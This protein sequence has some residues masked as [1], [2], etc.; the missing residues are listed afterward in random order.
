M[1][2]PMKHPITIP[3]LFLIAWAN[4]APAQTPVVLENAHFRYT[5][6]SEGQNVGF[7]GRATGKDYLKPGAV[8]PCAFIS[9][10]GRGY[11]ATGATLAEGR[12]ALRFEGAGADVGL[13]I[14]ARPSFIRLSVQSASPPDID[15]LVF[16]NVPL[17]LQGKPDEPFG[18]CAL[19]LNLMTRVDQLPALQTE[20]RAAC[21][22]K[23]GLAGAKAA[24]VAA[25]MSGMLPALKE[26]LLEADEMP[27]CKAAGPWAREAPFNRGSYLFNF[28]SLTEASADDWIEMARG[29][30]VTQIDN[31]G[32]GAGFFRFGDFALNRE[33]WPQGWETYSR[34]VARL[35]A[36]GIGSIFHSYA[37]F[38]DKQSKY[39][40]PVPDPR[41]D[42]FRTFTLA[43]AV[44]ADTN[45][46]RVNESTAG[47]RTITGFFEHNSV[48]L[49]VGDELVTFGGVSQQ[50]PWRFTG[51]RRGAFGTKAA[52]HAQGAPARHL[53]ECFGLLVP[54][55]ESS[56]FEE[57]AANHA[58]IVNQ[59]GFDGIY[60]DAI[61]GSSILRGGDECWY[62]ADKFVFEIQKR[63]K[64]PVGMEMSAMWHHFWQ[65]RTRWQAWDYPQRGHQR[66]LDLHAESVNGGLLLPLHLGWWNFQSFDPPQVEPTYPEV[67]EYLGAKLIGWDAGISLTGAID[68]ER[69]RSVPLFR[70]AVDVLHTCEQLRQGGDFD[71]KVKAQ[72]RQPG[73]EYALITN[74]AGQW[75]F[76]RSHSAPH[77]ASPAEPWTLSWR[78]NNPFARQP[79][80]LRLEALESAAAYEDPKAVVLADF[81]NLPAN[82][83][84]PTAAE[85]VSFTPSKTNME[86]GKTVGALAATN[87]GKAPRTAAW[88][89]LSKQFKPPLNLKE[90]QALGLWIE[91]VGLGELIVVRLESPQH[92]AFGAIADR[93]IPVD[94][95]GRR[96]F[97]LVETES[98]RWSDYVWN[99]GKSLYN[100]Y[101]ETIDFGAVE[102]VSVGYQNL[103]PGKEAKCRIGPV[104]ALPMLAGA[105]KNPALTCNG[106]TLVFPV[107][108]TSGGWIEFGGL[109][110]CVLYGPK[111]ERLKQVTPQPSAGQAAPLPTLQA[112][113]NALQFSCP[114]TSGPSPRVK[115]TVFCRGE[116]L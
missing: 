107:D 95:T 74:A 108:M 25:P 80:R 30:G 17:A 71:E 78:V 64:K 54:N 69:L 45:E 27:L 12:L 93:Y 81:T 43:E 82:E 59:C 111:G 65:Y 48:V 61:D 21:Y 79:L 22:R 16:L 50:R 41:L 24:I 6:S 90:Q 7:V 73:K 66:F 15:S 56:L 39:V 53:K 63:L 23:F 110:D 62:W 8:S 18:A 29:L 98:T 114:S 85:G 57:I 1:F 68:R 115:V 101:R 4:S 86:D 75:R 67:I 52:A 32:G 44:S 104:K 36:A 97:T 49:Q 83:W 19:S 26:V 47:L 40:T 100:V 76:R 11:P 58:A 109:D 2:E 20:L 5:I 13:S 106:T 84:T 113:E 87:T 3:G 55:P 91:G 103:P 72:L 77:T 102:S 28:G 94:F 38:I 92:L 14:E 31:H 46:V 10:Q 34:I 88:A 116:E 60:L 51:V 70:R 9:R 96:L 37:F 42:A 35:H 105:V 99:D 112:A 33:K 89:R